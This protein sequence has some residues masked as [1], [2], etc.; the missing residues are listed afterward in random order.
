MTNFLREKNTTPGR[1]DAGLF[2]LP[3]VLTLTDDDVV[4]LSSFSENDEDLPKRYSFSVYGETEADHLKD[5]FPESEISGIKIRTHLAEKRNEVTVFVHDPDG[6][7][8]G[9]G[10]FSL[11]VLLNEELS[12]EFDDLNVLPDRDVNGRLIPCV[13]LESVKVRPEFRGQGF[14]RAIEAAVVN[15]SSESLHALVEA[16]REKAISVEPCRVYAEAETE[17][18]LA[19]SERLY[20]ALKETGEAWKECLE[21]GFDVESEIGWF[22][23]ED[24]PEPA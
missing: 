14:A 20:A 3:R 11:S 7:V 15:L 12:D 22:G 18:G 16:A 23:P 2:R 21:F 24:D 4:T 5:V 6:D 19:F 17:G 9:Y 13:S 8:A 10:T 1:V